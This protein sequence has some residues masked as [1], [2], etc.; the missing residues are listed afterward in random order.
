MKV[1]I[2]G[3]MQGS[4]NDKKIFTQNYRTRIIEM[5]RQ[6][7][8]Q[9]IEFIDPDE[10][11]PDR[12]SYNTAQAKEMFIKYCHI[13]GTV[14]LLISYIPKASMGSAIEMWSAYSNNIPIITISPLEHNWVV[15]SLS[16]E[17]FSSIAELKNHIKLG[18]MDKY[19]VYNQKG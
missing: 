2:A 12:L 8:G 16:N 9:N 4:R 1:F 3:I 19:L 5:I 7:Y 14:D 13:A 18:T 6:K 17:I 10:T 15:K 11:D